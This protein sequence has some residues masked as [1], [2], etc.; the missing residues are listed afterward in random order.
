MIITLGK[1]KKLRRWS[2]RYGFT[3]IEL[4]VVMAI[5]AILSAI[6]FPV[7]AIV[8]ERARLTTCMSNLRQLGMASRMY[9]DDYDGQLFPAM[10]LYNPHFGL[11]RAWLPYVKSEGIFYCPN[12]SSSVEPTIAPTPENWA[13]GNIAYIY[14]NYIHDRN[15]YRPIWLPRGHLITDTGNPNRWLMTDWFQSNGETVHRLGKKT[16][17][18]LCMDGHVKMLLGQPRPIFQEGES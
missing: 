4:L 1:E 10:T 17:N 18:Y 5:I 3:L 11:T 2:S 8:R 13:A 9:T 7:F 15:T 16:M 12:A 14:F 6:V